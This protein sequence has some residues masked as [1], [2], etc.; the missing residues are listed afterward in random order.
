MKYIIFLI[1]LFIT[2]AK[3]PA[4]IDLPFD[5]GFS[6]GGSDYN[7]SFYG[8]YYNTAGSTENIVYYENRYCLKVDNETGWQFIYPTD[9][10]GNQSGRVMVEAWQYLGSDT[11][12]SW[13]RIGIG[14]RVKGKT[15]E[16]ARNSGYW[17]YA[18]TDNDDMFS[19]GT[20]L[21]NW[22]GLPNSRLY[23]MA[24]CQRDQ[25]H[26]WAIIADGYNIRF[27]SDTEGDFSQVFEVE[28]IRTLDPLQQFNNGYIGIGNYIKNSS[29]S[30]SYTDRIIIQEYTEVANWT[31][32]E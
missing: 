22:G 11:G 9:D 16:D 23:G 8:G 1:A 5:D 24:P 17:V 26:H 31:F 4:A 25:W 30:S 18:D 14:L 12:T 19:A 28:D 2:A 32:L 3:A 7:W 27:L 20:G 15:L 10:E 21:Q 29:G 6:A 13:A